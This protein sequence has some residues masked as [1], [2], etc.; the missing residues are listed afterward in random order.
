M[1]PSGEP[2]GFATA[3]GYD[4]VPSPLTPAGGGTTS[5]LGPGGLLDTANGIG[6][7]LSRTTFNE[8]GQE[9]SNPNYL[10]GGLQALRSFN[11]LKGQNLL[12]LAGAEL[13]NIGQGIL[14]GDTN[15]LNRL[16][17]PKPGAASGTNSL[18]QSA[19]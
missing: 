12:G 11:K 2:D 9:V 1:L 8:Q 17:L 6:Q 4:R 18:I 10:G 19:E 14:S 15:T 5:L 7:S 16:S 3:E 13:K